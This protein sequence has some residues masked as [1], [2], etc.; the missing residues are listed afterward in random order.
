[1]NEKSKCNYKHLGG[2]N[3]KMPSGMNFGTPMNG[4]WNNKP[5]QEAVYTYKT[6]S[7]MVDNMGIHA[8]SPKLFEIY[9]NGKQKQIFDVSE[10]ERRS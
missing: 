2:Y 5:Y 3:P 4:G 1:M 10:S 9:D 7:P 6:I 8:A